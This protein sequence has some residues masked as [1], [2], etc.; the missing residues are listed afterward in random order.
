MSSYQKESKMNAAPSRQ[1]RH[2]KRGGVGGGETKKVMKKR[3]GNGGGDGGGGGVKTEYLCAEQKG[4]QSIIFRQADRAV[5]GVYFYLNIGAVW[6]GYS[7]LVVPF[8][9]RFEDSCCPSVT[10]FNT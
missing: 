4:V 3:D 9:W 2:R 1:K 10:I 8:Q 7:R 5:W 6:I